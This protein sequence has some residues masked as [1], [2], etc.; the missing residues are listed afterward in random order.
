MRPRSD[1]ESGRAGHE[2]RPHCTH[3][4]VYRWIHPAVSAVRPLTIDA[5]TSTGLSLCVLDRVQRAV[6]Q[7][8]SS[9]LTA[10]T[11][12]YIGG[13]TQLESAVR[14]LLMDACT[15]TG[16][17][18][19]LRLRDQIRAGHEQQTRCTH[20]LLYRWIHPAVR[21]IMV[22]IIDDRSSTQSLSVCVL[23]RIRA[24]HEQRPHC[25]HNSVYRWI[26][27]A[28][29]ARHLTPASES[30]WGLRR[31]PQPNQKEGACA[32]GR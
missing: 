29:N 31:E 5:C 14:S 11:T 24:G 9:N 3:I 1:S 25:T 28:V 16:F 32:L 27:P 10:L 6:V 19:S 13:C 12:R 15:T 30:G 18:I 26:Y 21:V 20:N 4:L 23:G 7:V 2:Q 17:K 8:M 22:L